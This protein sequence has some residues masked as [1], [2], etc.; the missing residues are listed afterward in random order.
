MGGLKKLSAAILQAAEPAFKV[1][2]RCYDR[3]Y[4]ASLA[5]NK[6]CMEE[7]QREWA[8]DNWYEPE[9]H[10]WGEIYKLIQSV[11][12]WTVYLIITP[13]RVVFML[14]P[15]FVFLVKVDGWKTLWK[16]GALM[17]FVIGCL[18]KFPPGVPIQWI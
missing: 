12:S 15:L 13:A 18:L 7:A 4:I 6:F 8:W 17:A 3:V 5:Y 1:A 14:L 10:L 16:Q 9:T 2:N 11:V